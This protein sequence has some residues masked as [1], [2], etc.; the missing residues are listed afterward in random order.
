MVFL[1]LRCLQKSGAARKECKGVHILNNNNKTWLTTVGWPLVLP[2][3]GSW[4]WRSGWGLVVIDIS[5]IKVGM[6][7]GG[8]RPWG[9]VPWEELFL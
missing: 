8:I 9:H 2:G 5:A 1:T 7:R 4:K 3:E 6:A